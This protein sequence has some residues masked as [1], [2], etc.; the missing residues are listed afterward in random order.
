MAITVNSKNRSPYIERAC[1]LYAAMGDPCRLE[2]LN[3]LLGTYSELCVCDIA[4]HFE[5]GQPTISHHLK[6]LRDASLVSANKRGKW[7]YYSINKSAID[8]AKRLLVS[9]LS[10]SHYPSEQFG[11]QEHVPFGL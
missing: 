7:V 6:V 8:E 2:I 10:P 11:T 4:S 5:L 9:V 1:V 3:L